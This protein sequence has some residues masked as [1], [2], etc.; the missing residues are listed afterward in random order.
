MPQSSDQDP[1]AELN[2]Y[3]RW[4]IA[5][6]VQFAAC[7]A[8]AVFLFAWNLSSSA[9]DGA[10]W[11]VPAFFGIW[12][13]WSRGGPVRRA[14]ETKGHEVPPMVALQFFGIMAAIVV[15]ALLLVHALSS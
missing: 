6:P 11:A 1:H 5:H 8:M 15:T 9:T 2:P 10:C 4:A 7:G 14:A 12:I 13:G 3:S